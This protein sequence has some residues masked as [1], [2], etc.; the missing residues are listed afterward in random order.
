M[1]LDESFEYALWNALSSPTSN[2]NFG[3][4]MVGQGTEENNVGNDQVYL[5]CNDNQMQ[6]QL[7]AGLFGGVNDD[8]IMLPEVG[9][10]KN[11][12]EVS[13][14]FKGKGKEKRK[15]KGKEIDLGNEGSDAK[16]KG[17][18]IRRKS[19]L[20][21]RR[22]AARVATERERRLKETKLFDVLRKLLPDLPPEVSYLPKFT[23]CLSRCLSYRFRYFL[24]FVFILYKKIKIK[25]RF[26]NLKRSSH[27]LWD[28]IKDIPIS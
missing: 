20:R 5:G 18:K 3:D 13:K 1:A 4:G 6:Q 22:L 8:K 24:C 17:K 9:V 16:E 25:V 26:W 14:K 19:N 28:C 2:A 27:K 7:D 10:R 23:T 12:G 15:G 21:L 11:D